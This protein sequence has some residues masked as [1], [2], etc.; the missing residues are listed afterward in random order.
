MIRRK[1]L[2]Q[3]FIPSG[4]WLLDSDPCFTF[5]FSTHR[6]AFLFISLFIIRRDAKVAHPVVEFSINGRLVCVLMRSIYG[7]LFHSLPKFS[8]AH[9]AR[10]AATNII[11]QRTV[12]SN[13][14][15][16]APLTRHLD[17]LLDRF[18]RLRP[19]LCIQH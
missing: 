13:D 17:P 8:R 10:A 3:I 2:L 15:E 1:P 12:G 6:S 9:N 16:R 4:S 14:N 18:T 5:A 19:A 7:G 11:S